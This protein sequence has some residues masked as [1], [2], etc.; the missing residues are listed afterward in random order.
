MPDDVRRAKQFRKKLT[1]RADIGIMMDVDKDEFMPTEDITSLEECP[2]S[3]SVVTSVRN[4]GDNDV[5]SDARVV[6]EGRIHTHS[7]HGIDPKVHL[8][9]VALVRSRIGRS[10][11]AD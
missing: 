8:I 11:C 3:E 6:D 4:K 1:E 7:M 10:S 5:V 9:S 2:L